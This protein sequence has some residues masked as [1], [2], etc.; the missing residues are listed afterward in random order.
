MI[1]TTVAVYVKDGYADDFIKATI[2]NHEN[3]I[4]E[5]GNLRFDIL[6]SN[7]DPNRFTLYEAYATKEAATKHKETA[8]Y[9]KWRETVA[10]WMQRPREGVAHSV[11]APQSKD[12]W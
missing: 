11:L 2:E 1:V 12:L 10:D 3:S 9:L 4:K 7:D 8:H 6:Q 5:D